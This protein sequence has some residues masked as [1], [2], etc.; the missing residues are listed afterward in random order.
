MTEDKNKTNRDDAN[1]KTSSYTP[2]WSQSAIE[3][4]AGTYHVVEDGILTAQDFSVLFEKD[5]KKLLIPSGVTDTINVYSTI[6]LSSGFLDF[7]NKNEI[8]LNVF[9][10]FG[11][12]VGVFMPK[13]V[14]N[15]S[16]TAM[17]QM[18]CFCDCVGRAY[19]ARKIQLAAAHN[20]RANLRYYNE[21]Y[22][23]DYLK[24]VIDKIT[25]K[26]KELEKIEVANDMLMVEAQIRELYY[27]C[28]NFILYDE[29]FYFDKRTKNPPESALNALISFGNVLL[30]QKVATAIRKSSLDIRIG[31]IHSPNRRQE[32][33]QF[34]LAEIFKPIIVDR[35]IFSLINKQIISEELHFEKIGE[36][37]VYLN[38]VGKR[39]FIEAFEKK[40]G[41]YITIKGV[42]MTYAALIKEEIHKLI[43]YLN[44][45]EEYVPYKYI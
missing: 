17:E 35:V 14:E 40:L 19:I 23:N 4:T 34:D 7:L 41:T 5:E 32:T 43:N 27:S 9:D 6:V 39:I 33:L 28:F 25:I 16:D 37:A 38:K 15:S 18:K 42:R 1:K 3:K 21:R 44:N 10:R 11:N 31:F 30:Y 20:I 13:S 2:F 8:T 29:D 26:M 45:G 24:Q 22:E 12:Y 36:K